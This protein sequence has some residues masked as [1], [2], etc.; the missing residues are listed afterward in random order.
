[1]YST[2]NRTNTSQTSTGSSSPY[3]Q[4]RVDYLGLQAQINF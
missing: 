2:G 1:M 3:D 4:A